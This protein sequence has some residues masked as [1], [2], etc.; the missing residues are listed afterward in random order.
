ME[1]SEAIKR[2]YLVYGKVHEQEE[3]KDN[4]LKSTGPPQTV[5][6]AVA[7]GNMSPYTD[8]TSVMLSCTV[9][10]A[11]PAA[12][13]QWKKD[14]TDLTGETSSMLTISMAVETGA[15]SCEASNSVASN[16]GS[17]SET[18]TILGKM[19]LIWQNLEHGA[20]ANLWSISKAF[21]SLFTIF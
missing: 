10:D 6:V 7:N 8:G 1:F 17:N 14:G 21:L 20:S 2:N 9:T 19:T 4:S 3:R 11:N 16:V 12:T 15:Y 5:T 18:V 13:I